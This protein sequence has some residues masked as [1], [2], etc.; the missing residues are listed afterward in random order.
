MEWT[1]SN[2]N[3]RL[4]YKMLLFCVNLLITFSMRYDLIIYSFRD[5]RYFTCSLMTDHHRKYAS[6]RMIALVFKKGRF[7]KILAFPPNSI[8]ILSWG[9]RD[10]LDHDKASA[11]TGH[12]S[13]G[14]GANN[15]QNLT[16]C[17][18]PSAKLEEL[19]A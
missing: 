12:E 19:G 5:R 7:S 9:I 6:A 15:R 18:L 3:R 10:N 2:C 16:K 17:L 14:D 13:E 8:V 1:L 11:Q 4:F